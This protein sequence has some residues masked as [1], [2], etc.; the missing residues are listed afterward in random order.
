MQNLPFFKFDAESWLTGKIQALR[1]EQVGIYINL[2][3][4]IW[5]AG[6]EIKRD[7][8]LHRLI[9]CNEEQLEAAISDFKELGIMIDE[10]GVLRVKFLDEQL[11]ARQEFLARCSAGGSK[12]A[13][14]QPT[15]KRKVTTS[16]LEDNL[17]V[18][19]SDLEATLKVTTSDLEGDLKSPPS[20]TERRKKKEEIQKE[21]NRERVSAR[22]RACE[23]ET[24]NTQD[25]SQVTHAPVPNLGY[26]KNPE[27]VMAKATMA[28]IQGA[29]IEEAEA[30]LDYYSSRGWLAG[31]GVR[32]VNWQASF[33]NWLRKSK[34]KQ[35]I[36]A[37]NGNIRGSITEVR[38]P[39]IEGR[40]NVAGDG[41]KSDW[42]RFFGK[43]SDSA[44]T[45][46]T[47]NDGAGA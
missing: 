5:R 40:F 26:P 32:I 13:A 20:N 22:A 23:E 47:G 41:Y 39:Y 43:G 34:E 30:F 11:E 19:T 7:R 28:G 1:I 21:E 3:A 36:G 46:E 14:R 33:R 42:E 17:K 25:F 29:T 35:A 18:T 2:V 37:K 10:G 4:R 45:G 24:Q 38:Q 8:F 27:E 12:R 31:P 16:D 15:R 44:G 6:G 9:G